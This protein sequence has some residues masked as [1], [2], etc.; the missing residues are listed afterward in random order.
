MPVDDH[1]VVE[2]RDHI[3]PALAGH[4]GCAYT[5]PPQQREHALSLVALLLGC[6]SHLVDD[7]ADVDDVGRRRPAHDHPHHDPSLTRRTRCPTPTP[8][9]RRASTR[10]PAAGRGEPLLAA[11]LALLAPGPLLAGAALVTGDPALAAL[12]GRVC[13]TA[14]ELGALLAALAALRP[15][16]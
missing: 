10:R 7:R 12:A 8:P 5:S 2:V 15:V 16:R 4:E 13:R 3:N 14:L 6:P 1:V 11:V 9:P